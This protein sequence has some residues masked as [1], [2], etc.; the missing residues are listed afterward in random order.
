MRNYLFQSQRSPDTFDNYGPFTLF[1]AKYFDGMAWFN[2]MMHINKQTSLCAGWEPFDD[3][4]QLIP[5]QFVLGR[6]FNADHYVFLME[7]IFQSLSILS[8]ERSHELLAQ[9]FYVSQMDQSLFM[10]IFLNVL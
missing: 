4:N 6:N 2:L 5:I 9:T 3:I 7:R 10:F 8:K 1:M